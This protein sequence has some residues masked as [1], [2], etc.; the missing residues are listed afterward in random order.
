MAKTKIVA[1]LGPSSDSLEAVRQL[2]HG[3]VSVV[4]LNMSHGTHQEHGERIQRVRQAAKEQNAQTAILMDL[5][6]PKIRLGTF[7][8]GGCIL[9]EGGRFVLTTQQV[10]G[11]YERASCSY[12]ELATDVQAGDRV[13]LADGALELRVCSSD[14]TEVVCDVVC[15]RRF[16]TIKAST[17]RACT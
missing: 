13:L 5:Q 2:I 10:A 11:T 16:P 4:R 7:E 3:G 1:T 15:G 17:C 9:E 12:P 6:G 14:G 8:K